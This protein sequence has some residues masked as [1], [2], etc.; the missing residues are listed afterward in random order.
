MPRHPPARVLRCVDPVVGSTFSAL[1]IFGSEILSRR[2]LRLRLGDPLFTTFLHFRER[3]YLRRHMCLRLA[4]AFLA[5]SP[6]PSARCSPRVNLGKRPSGRRWWPHLL[7]ARHRPC[8]CMKACVPFSRDMTIV[9]L[10][11]VARWTC[12]G[13][14]DMGCVG[15][16]QRAHAS[17]VRRRRERGENEVQRVRAV[18]PCQ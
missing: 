4:N 12:R 14:R 8:E 17:M 10:A 18:D 15:G 7:F 1:S 2:T 13:R 3:G 6:S 5:S 9:S 11:R 16:E